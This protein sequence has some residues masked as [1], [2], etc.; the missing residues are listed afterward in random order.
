MMDLNLRSWNFVC[1]SE[2]GWGIQKSQSLH[3]ILS[4][5]YTFF[6]FLD[7]YAWECLWKKIFFLPISIFLWFEVSAFRKSYS[8]FLN[9]KSTI[10]RGGLKMY[11]ILFFDLFQ[12]FPSCFQSKQKYRN[13]MSSSSKKR[14]IFLNNSLKKYIFT[15][16]FI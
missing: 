3:L 7:I 15:N 1:L 13:A 8:Y 4:F 5:W 2:K 10:S 6:Q 9:F 12:P 14:Y 11:T 16:F